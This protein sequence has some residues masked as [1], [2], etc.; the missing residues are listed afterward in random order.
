[1]EVTAGACAGS[2]LCKRRRCLKDE[3]GHGEEVERNAVIA[4]SAPHH[5][6]KDPPQVCLA[7]RLCTRR[8]ESHELQAQA[9]AAVPASNPR[10]DSKA[11]EVSRELT[12]D[13]VE[14]GVYPSYTLALC[15]GSMY[16]SRTYGTGPGIVLIF[17][18]VADPHKYYVFSINQKYH[19]RGKRGLFIIEFPL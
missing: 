19:I 7:L 14:K 3:H 2:A 13:Q 15:T 9:L 11:M 16:H 4:D 8:G 1:M 6:A 5:C 12:V 17:S 18:R 10:A